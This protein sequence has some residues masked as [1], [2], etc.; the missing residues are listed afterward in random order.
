VRSD[1]YEDEKPNQKTNETVEADR[2][3]QGALDDAIPGYAL[4][5]SSKHVNQDVERLPP[6]QGY[7]WGRSEKSNIRAVIMT[8]T[9][10]PGAANSGLSFSAQ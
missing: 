5:L 8:L 7:S 6:I 10:E 3:V 9:K 1:L 4:L 2:L